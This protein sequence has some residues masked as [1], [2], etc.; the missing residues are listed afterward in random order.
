MKCHLM[1]KEMHIHLRQFN[2]DNKQDL[3]RSHINGDNKHD[4]TS[5]RIKD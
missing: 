4:L 5:S 3:T 1:E 2:G